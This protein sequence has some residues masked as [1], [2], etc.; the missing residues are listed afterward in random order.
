[1]ALPFNPLLPHANPYPLLGFCLIA[2]SLV[3]QNNAPRENITFISDRQGQPDAAW[4]SE[5]RQRPV[6][7]DFL[8]AHGTW[9]VEFNENN[10]KPHR[11]YGRPIATS[12]STPLEHALNFI[13]ADLGGFGIPAGELQLLSVAPTPKQTYVH[14]KQMHGGLDVLFSHFLVKLDNSGRAIAFG[15]DVYDA[16]DLDLAPATATAD[17]IVAASAG[18]TGITGS[19]VES[20]PAILPVPAFKGTE[21]HLVYQ[22]TVNTMNDTCPGTT[23]AWWM[24]TMANCSI[25]TTR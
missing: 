25:A 12:G 8:A 17:A 21:F 23:A 18:L 19:T 5:L 15:A 4:Q 20:A 14:F 16:I 11:A 10:A 2:S 24:R 13:S 1:L 22:V 9:F 3:A 7:Q 6:W